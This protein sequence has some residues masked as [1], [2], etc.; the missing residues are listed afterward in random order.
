MTEG[1]RIQKI[2][3]YKEMTLEEFGKKIGVDKSSLSKIEKGKRNLTKQQLNS[4]CIVYGVSE[5]WLKTGNG[6]MLS[7]CSLADELKEKIDSFIPMEEEDFRL[8][9]VRMILAMDKHDMEQLEK[10]ANKYLIKDMATAA[11][12]PD[13]TAAIPDVPDTDDGGMTAAGQPEES[14]TIFTTQ[15][16]TLL[17]FA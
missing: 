17:P 3:A 11:D 15:D 13:T 4:I 7:D 8:R 2:R 12:Q 1:E 9:L 10:Y 6:Q 16:D 14:P 5:E